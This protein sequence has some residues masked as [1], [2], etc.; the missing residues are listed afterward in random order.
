MLRFTRRTLDGVWGKDMDIRLD[1]Y[2]REDAIIE[3]FDEFHLIL[4]VCTEEIRLEFHVEIECVFIIYAVNSD[5]IIWLECRK[6][7]QTSLYLTWEYVDATDNHHVIR[8]SEDAVHAHTGASA[9]AF[10]VVETR[11]VTRAIA[12]YWHCL[13]AERGENEFAKLARSHRFQC[14]WI[15][16]LRIEH[17]LPKVSAVLILTFTAHARTRGNIRL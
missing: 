10:L 3:R 5:E 7:R 6:L 13:L 12:Q 15:D 9:L 11:K 16:D 1:A 2:H 8:T 17:V 4:W 14:V